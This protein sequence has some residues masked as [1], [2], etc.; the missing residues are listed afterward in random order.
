MTHNLEV[1]IARHE[2]EYRE[3]Y[4]LL[5][6]T[7]LR[8]GFCEP[9]ESGVFVRESFTQPDSRTFIC[10][11][12]EDLVGTLTVIGGQCAGIQLRAHYP[13]AMERIYARKGRIVEC[14]GLA[15][16]PADQIQNGSVFLHLTRFMFQYVESRGYTDIVTMAHPRVAEFYR[17][18][19]CA[20]SMGPMVEVAEMRGNPGIGCHIQVEHAKL[21]IR[22]T[23]AKWFYAGYRFPIEVFW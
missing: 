17:Q 2:H 15:A 5:Y 23:L 1:R 10:V 19:L 6:D 21:K 18:Y 22:P 16:L 14:T 12:G 4:K 9:S 11:Q 20:V 7:F 13:E 8:M 3:A